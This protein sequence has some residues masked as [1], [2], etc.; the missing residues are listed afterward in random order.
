M[1]IFGKSGV[2][3]TTLLRN[4][5]LADLHAGNGLTVID[6]HGS[7]VADLINCIPPNR[8]N[9]EIYLNPAHPER[10]IGLN[11]LQSVG[12]EQRSLVVSSIISILRNL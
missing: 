2:G 9:D 8:T 11:V 12:R 1:A 5:V 4:M 10:V 6:P 7:L 3:K